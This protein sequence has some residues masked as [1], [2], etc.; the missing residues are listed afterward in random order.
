MND[1]EDSESPMVLMQMLMTDVDALLKQIAEHEWSLYTIFSTN[2]MN[3]TPS[4]KY[5]QQVALD[6]TFE[7]ITSFDNV[8]EKALQK[9]FGYKNNSESPVASYRECEQLARSLREMG[10]KL[11]ESMVISKIV[12]L[13]SSSH[14]DADALSRLPLKPL[15]LPEE[16]S[17]L[18][19]P[20]YALCEEVS[21]I[22]DIGIDLFEAKKS[23]ADTIQQL[24]DAMQDPIWLDKQFDTGSIIR[25]Q[26]LC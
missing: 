16:D 11:D 20:V 9:F 10:V 15:F 5:D 21:N 12:S 3:C 13:K 19:F 4:G 22:V 24:E 7:L 23:E 14:S 1:I 17:A 18:E 8:R 2:E 6:L 26:I 25:I